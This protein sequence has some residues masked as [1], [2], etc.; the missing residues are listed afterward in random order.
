MIKMVLSN[1]A[2]TGIDE[3]EARIY[4]NENY[5]ASDDA[6]FVANGSL[7]IEPLD[8]WEDDET[9]TNVDVF[10][11]ISSDLEAINSNVTINMT[12]SMEAIAFSN[13]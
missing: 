4:F 9:I 13:K 1:I 10:N 6:M 12:I 3:M 7:R 5:C 8:H 11:K 2:I